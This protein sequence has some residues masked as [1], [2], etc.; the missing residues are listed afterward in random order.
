MEVIM[1]HELHDPDRRTGHLG[2]ADDVVHGC[3]LQ[4]RDTFYP[5]VPEA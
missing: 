2:F 1:C 4:G 3:W 5:K